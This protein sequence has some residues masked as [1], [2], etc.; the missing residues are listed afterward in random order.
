MKTMSGFSVV[1]VLMALVLLG[2]VGAI[3][4][5][6]YG[7]VRTIHRDQ[8]RK[9]AMNAIHH[10]LEEIVR[11]ALG[12]YPRTISSAQL[13]A[14]DPSYLKDPTGDSIGQADS[15]YRYEPT[16]CGGGDVCKGYRLTAK[17]EGESDFVRTSPSS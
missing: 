9:T 2:F 3:A 10:N 1:E 15:D 8:Q 12:G 7:A 14:I 5:D 16:G 17:L 11:P 13:T 4:F 6:R